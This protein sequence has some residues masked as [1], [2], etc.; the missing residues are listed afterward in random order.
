MDCDNTQDPK[1]IMD[2][3]RRVRV[4]EKEIGLDI[5][6]ALRFQNG[7]SV[8]GLSKFRNLTSAGAKPVYSSILSIKDVR[9]LY[10]WL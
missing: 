7:S 2:M 8:K 9:R 10:L 1:Y 3:L 6:I 5:I 4:N